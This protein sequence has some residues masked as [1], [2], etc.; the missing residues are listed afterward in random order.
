MRPKPR[1]Q[2][3]QPVVLTRE[4][5]VELVG[6]ETAEEMLREARGE[7]VDGIT[8]MA[9]EFE[10]WMLDGPDDPFNDRK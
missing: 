7:P 6:E 2:E 5:L 9:E 4:R 1:P 10:R 8:M 3:S